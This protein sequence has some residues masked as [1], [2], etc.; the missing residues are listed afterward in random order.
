MG[1][2]FGAL[3]LALSPGQRHTG[4]LS[5]IS[6]AAAA[7]AICAVRGYSSGLPRIDPVQQL[8]AAVRESVDDVT[9]DPTAV[10]GAA[11]S[12]ISSFPGGGALPA[13][14]L[15]AAAAGVGAVY[16]HSA[17]NA[18]VSGCR[19]ARGSVDEGC[20]VGGDDDS[21]EEEAEAQ[22]GAGTT[23][24]GAQPSQESFAVK[25]AHL[26]ADCVVGRRSPSSA[27]HALRRRMRTMAAGASLA[28]TAVNVG[29]L[30]LALASGPEAVLDGDLL[31]GAHALLDVCGNLPN[32][33]E[34]MSDLVHL[35]TAV[36]LTVDAVSGRLPT[37]SSSGVP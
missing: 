23:G 29:S 19:N 11:A 5:R 10:A 25:V 8:L 20:I 37:A 24:G 3:T 14:A 28:W 30:C 35:G 6:R 1:P 32:L 17:A 26:I 13:P 2:N 12:L 18:V 9:G 4:H 34:V 33:G 7:A 31:H 22:S 27:R 36:G 21:D 15:L 16:A